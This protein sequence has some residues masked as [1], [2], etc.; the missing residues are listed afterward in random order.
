MAATGVVFYYFGRAAWLNWVILFTFLV[1]Y[2]C[3]SL[4][5]VFDANSAKQRIERGL[6]VYRF[7]ARH[8]TNGD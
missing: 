5:I 7:S 2:V 4:H 6:D 8:V 3:A 1:L